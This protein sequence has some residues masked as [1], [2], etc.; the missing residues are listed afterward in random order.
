MWGNTGSNLKSNKELNQLVHDVILADDFN[1]DDLHGFRALKELS[2]L[3]STDSGDSFFSASAG[4]RK[5]SIKIPVP[6]EKVK[7][8]EENA[9]TFEV[10]DIYMHRLVDIIREVCEDPDEKMYNWRPFKEFWQCPKD[11]SCTSRGSSVDQMPAETE[12]VCIYSELYNSDAMLEE[13]AKI[14][15]RPCEPGDPDDVEPAVVPIMLWSDATRL[16]NFDTASLWPIYAYFGFQSKYQHAQRHSRSS[17][18]LA[19][20]PKLPD[21]F[22]DWYEETYGEPASADV[23]RFCRRELY[24]VIWLLQLDPEFMHAYEHGILL[25]CR[26]G[27]LHRLFLR[28]FTYSADYP[29]KILLACI[30]YLAQ[31]LC[32]HCLIKKADI[33]DMDSH[34]DMLR[35]A[36]F[37]ADSYPVQYDI[38][39][40]R[41]WIFEKGYGPRSKHIANILDRYLLVP[42]RSAFSIHLSEFGFDFY[43]M[44]VVDLMHEFELGVWK[45]I[46]T[47]LLQIFYAEGNNTIQRFNKRHVLTV[48]HC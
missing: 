5:Y 47:H 27:V 8:P 29:E 22:Q 33:P 2:R 24:H 25:C 30:R 21:D 16:A 4:W 39:K 14:H 41:H 3:D 35:R 38:M 46:L 45:A 48:L 11:D 36:K 9:P 19:Y 15:A 7:L 37:R 12:N 1:P 20:I 42:S 23:L 32:P 43:P 10:G 13:D 6:K 26:D 17:H 18:H 40:T 34:M 31:C 28:F 44:F